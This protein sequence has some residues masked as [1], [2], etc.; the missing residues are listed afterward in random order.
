MRWRG[1][2]E[3]SGCWKTICTARAVARVH[4]GRSHDARLFEADF[5]LEAREPGHGAGE[6]RFARAGF[7]DDPENLGLA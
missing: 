2:S 1:L 7:A 6:R 3:A 4:I 5:A